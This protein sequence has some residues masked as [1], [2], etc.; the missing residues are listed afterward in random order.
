MYE[1]EEK[2]RKISKTDK[3]CLKIA[4]RIIEGR[5]HG[6]LRKKETKFF[7]AGCPK[8]SIKSRNSGLNVR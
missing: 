1:V 8:G 6:G 7:K 4:L 5:R 3:M 2:V